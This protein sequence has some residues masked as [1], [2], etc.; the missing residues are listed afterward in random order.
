MKNKVVQ[1]PLRYPGS[2]FKVFKYIKPFIDALPHD[3][4]REPF[5]GS[6]AVFF[7]KELASCNWLN[8]LDE[9]LMIFYKTIQN[10]TKA[11][12]LAKEVEKVCPSKEYFNQLKDSMPT[13]DIEKAFKYFVLNRTAYG[14]IMNMPNWGFHTIKS[15]QP[16]KW[17]ERILQ[18]SQKL[19]DIELSSF[20]YEKLL[21]E[22]PKGNCV[23][24]FIDPPYYKAD[25]KR[26]YVKSFEKEDHIKLAENLK[27]TPYNFILTYD[28]DAEIRKLYDWAYIYPIEFKYN[29]ANSKVATRK[30]GK[31]LIITNKKI[32]L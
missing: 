4:Y 15:V 2:K 27:T 8:D 7:K 5:L 30:T 17:G 9:D 14:G 10:K 12:I 21:F 1:T 25:Q 13:T 31:E 26:A 6:G 20:S 23:L 3:E 16:N 18:A 11:E 19:Q 29:T 32:D 24:L 22:K 28:D